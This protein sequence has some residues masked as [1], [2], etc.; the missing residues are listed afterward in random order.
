MAP[1]TRRFHYHANAHVLSAHFT[2]PILHDI[3]V[4]AAT[5]L[6]TTGGVGS[7][8]VENFRFNEHISFKAG[9]SHVSGSEKVENN[10]IIHTTMATAVIEGLNILDM[11]T[12]DRIVARLS[13]SYESGQESRIL[14]L[15]SKFE[16]LR[17]ACCK[18]EV[19]LHHELAFKLDTFEAIRNEF[20][21]NADFRKMAE[22]PF[23]PGKLPEKIEPHGVVHC[24]LVKDIQPAKCPGVLR[25][26]HHGHVLEVPDF[27]KVFL[28]EILF[29]HGRKTLTML[30]VELGSPNGGGTTVV[31]ASSN[32]LPPSG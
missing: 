15:G 21:N 27:G 19:E 30:R 4:Q 9:Y 20:A 31:E 28:A 6:P 25:Y 14:I 18:I 2:R 22:D 17:V 3:P 26:G 13:S 29:Q 7:A 23:H 11:V 16:N 32:G 5:S 10:K 8:R 24:S 12:A 1:H